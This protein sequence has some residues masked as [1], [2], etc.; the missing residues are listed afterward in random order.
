MRWPC[1]PI[2]VTR[3]SK[4]KPADSDLRKT[5]EGW[6]Q[7]ATLQ[8]LKG[9]SINCL[10]VDWASGTA[11]DE[12]QQKALKPLITAGRELGISFVGKVGTRENLAAIVA[13][14]RAAGLEAVM[15]DGPANHSLGLPVISGFPRDSIDWDAA[16]EIFSAT[17][18][19]WPGVVLPTMKGDTGVGGPTG[20]PWMDSNGWFALLARQMVPHRSLW[21][22]IDLPESSGALPVE[23]YCRA[24]AD[25]RAY[26]SHWVLTLDGAIRTG[27]LNGNPQDL[28]A[29]KSIAG[30]LSFF[31]EHAEWAAYKPMGILAVVSDFR[32]PNSFLSGET[33]N[34]LSRRHV[35]YAVLD[36]RLAL[37]GPV[38]GL[39]AVLWTD[40][41]PPT[42]EQH[43]NLLDFVEQGGL[44][45]APKYWGPVGVVPRREYWL[46]GYDIYDVGKG[47]I[48][49]ASEGFSD[50]FQLARDAHLLV[51][52][53]NDLARL[54]NPGTTNCFT[55]MGPGHRK[56]IVQIVNY[57]SHSST[58]L[59]VWVSLHAHAARLWSPDSKTPQSLECIPE[60]GGTSFELPEFHVNCA[61]EIERMV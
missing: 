22:E 19:V 43:R 60:S 23:S 24:I 42:S 37:T 55:S 40:D 3:I 26:G 29:W 58:Y 45:I 30:A 10:V 17:G 11:D 38:T 44:T 20:E 27:M 36:R 46:P 12:S 47:R 54:F 31:E 50:P 34:L 9:T 2:E 25:S 15:I 1:G 51:G 6:T 59:A 18:N 32:G 61:I 14:G 49:V 39:K 52:R 57:A 53:E 5:V 41:D 21:L 48:V 7:P 13:A 8:L 35:Q 4:S 28:S 33:L 56:E 16:T